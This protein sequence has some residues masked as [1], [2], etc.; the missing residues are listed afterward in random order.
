MLFI[1]KVD[2]V[3]AIPHFWKTFFSADPARPY[4]ILSGSLDGAYSVGTGEAVWISV[5]ENRP[6]RIEDVLAST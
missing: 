3:V 2:T 5:K 6:V 1:E 4:D